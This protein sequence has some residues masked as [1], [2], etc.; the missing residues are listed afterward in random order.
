MSKV[1]R[2]RSMT[3]AKKIQEAEKVEHPAGLEVP[4]HEDSPKEPDKPKVVG[5]IIIEVFDN[6]EFGTNVQ[7]V[8]PYA[9]PTILETV[10]QRVKAELVS[11]K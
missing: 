5:R 4:L 7:S 8:Y 11:K 9:V 3:E 6:G 10:A 1:Q 2:V